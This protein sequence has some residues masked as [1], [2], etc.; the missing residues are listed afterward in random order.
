M[1]LFFGYEPDSNDLWV[2]K[3]ILEGKYSP[4]VVVMEFNGTIAKGVNKTIKY[5]PNAVWNNNDYYGASFEALRILGIE[6]GYTLVLQVATTNMIF[7]RSD[8]VAQ[9]DYG[10]DYVPMQ[11]HAHANYGEW[12]EYKPVS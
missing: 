9:G 5:N 11:Y 8:I 7:I 2:W 1:I 3:V 10:I 6:K 4:R 12:V